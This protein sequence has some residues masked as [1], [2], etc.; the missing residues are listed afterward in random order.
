MKF[1]LS[2]AAAKLY[3]SGHETAAVFLPGFAINW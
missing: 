3:V 1:M 2:F